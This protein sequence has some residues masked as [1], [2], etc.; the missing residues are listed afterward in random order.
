MDSPPNRGLTCPKCG[1]L[2]T[3][4]ADICW[5]CGN[6]FP[7]A[8]ILEILEKRSPQILEADEDASSVWSE[9]GFLVDLLI[10]MF[11]STIAFFATCL[12]IGVKSTS[13]LWVPNIGGVVAAVV[14]AWALFRLFGIGAPKKSNQRRRNDEER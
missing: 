1:T 13:S 6:E 10:V 12:S 3:I 11:A 8:K 9:L 14:V 7:D 5:K 4:G 2:L